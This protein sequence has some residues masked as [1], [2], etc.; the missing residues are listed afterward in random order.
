MAEEVVSD[1]TAAAADTEAEAGDSSVHMPEVVHSVHNLEGDSAHN[2]VVADLVRMPAV[3]SVRNPDLDFD[4][5]VRP[6]GHSAHY[7][8]PDY[9]APAGCPPHQDCDNSA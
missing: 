6:E 4:W 1:R 5:A 7:P 9:R 2:P 3:D 8:V